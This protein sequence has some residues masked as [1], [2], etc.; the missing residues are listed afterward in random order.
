[1]STELSTNRSMPASAV[2][3]VLLY[4]SVPEAVTW[5]CRALGFTERLR[6]GSHRVQLVSPGG[7]GAVVVAEGH[8]P[9]ANASAS[10]MV[11]IRGLDDHFQ[12]A[13]ANGAVV[14]RAPE[15]HV[16]GERQYTVADPDGHVWTFSE[17][18][19]DV[20]PRSWGGEYLGDGGDA[21]A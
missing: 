15:T 20:A 4:P 16:Y 2:I 7:L 12:T 21:A 10:V 17:S 11:R 6:I 3:P 8:A 5:L 19:D 13:C 9:G 1:M 14:L 18:V